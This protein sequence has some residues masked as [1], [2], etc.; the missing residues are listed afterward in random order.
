MPSYAD[1]AREPELISPRKPEVS[2]PLRNITRENSERASGSAT[3]GTLYR[4]H[5]LEELETPEGQ[6]QIT[7]PEKIG[8]LP[9]SPATLRVLQQAMIGV[10]N[11]QVGTGY[12][13]HIPD[14][15][16]AGKTGTAQNPHGEAHAWFVGYAP[17]KNPQIV[18]VVLIENAGHGGTFSAPVGK[19]IIERFFKKDMMQAQNDSIAPLSNY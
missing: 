8:Q 10:V 16:V 1:L 13:A 5:L 17:A 15:L 11:D 4:P 18:V 3:D 9:F 6:N 2:S 7:Q 14:I 19:K 12:L